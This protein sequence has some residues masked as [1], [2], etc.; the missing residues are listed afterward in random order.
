MLVVHGTFPIRPDAVE[1]L[2]A[3]LGPLQAAT[4]EEEGCH[5]YEWVRSVEQPEVF[6]SVEVWRAREDL[7]RHMS[8]DH[9]ATALAGL[10]DMLAGQPTLVGYDGGE[11]VE[12][13]L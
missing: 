8:T 5:F 7:D 2:H 13:S 12:L 3:A 1:A 4:R 10:P 9:V 6:Y 11:R